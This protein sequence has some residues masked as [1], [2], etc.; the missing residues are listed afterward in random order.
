MFMNLTF[1]ELIKKV[2]EEHYF[3]LLANVVESNLFMDIKGKQSIDELL[4]KLQSIHE[5]IMIDTFRDVPYEA[6]Q[7]G[8]VLNE[9]EEDDASTNEEKTSISWLVN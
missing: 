2:L 3:P 7:A 6:N 5:K 1:T 9:D 4:S 8:L